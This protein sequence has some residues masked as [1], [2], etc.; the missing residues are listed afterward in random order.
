MLSD[1]AP[2]SVEQPR[3]QLLLVVV[4]DIYSTL[5]L[6]H[7]TPNNDVAVCVREQEAIL[8]NLKI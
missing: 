4:Q 2:G 6:F 8:P 3:G 5:G 1:T 7:P